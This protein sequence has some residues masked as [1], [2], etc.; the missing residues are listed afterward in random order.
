[1]GEVV[2]H[3]F[4]EQIDYDDM[5][6][7]I[8]RRLKFLE[9]SPSRYVASL[10][11]GFRQYKIPR[12]AVL[13]KFAWLDADQNRFIP[14]SPPWEHEQWLKSIHYDPNTYEILGPRERPAPQIQRIGWQVHGDAEHL[15]QAERG[16]VHAFPQSE[17]RSEAA[18]LR[19]LG[20]SERGVVVPFQR[21]ASDAPEVP[22]ESA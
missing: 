19:G 13:R 10:Y 20:R 11:E 18:A 14:G 6:D 22:L 9:G 2:R 1:M 17:Q 3:S 4:G 15:L 12:S 8:V 7:P 16:A 21:R 5:N